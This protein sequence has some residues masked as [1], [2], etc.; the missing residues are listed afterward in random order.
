MIKICKVCGKEFEGKANSTVCSGVCRLEYQKQYQIQYKQ[1]NKDYLKNYNK[2]W[3]A[4]HNNQPVPKKVSKQDSLDNI[5]CLKKPNKPKAMPDTY[6]ASSWGR[7][8]WKAERLDKIVMLSSALS[9]W[10]IARLSYGQLSAIFE[11]GRYMT[12]LY[13]V[14]SLEE[15]A[16]HEA[17]T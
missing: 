5:V 6:K 9:K 1:E 8:Y 3:Y 10:N 4:M 2:R 13:D 14:L 15:Q 7:K 11:S 17:I 16:K 12:M